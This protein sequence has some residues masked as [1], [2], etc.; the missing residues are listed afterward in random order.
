MFGGMEEMQEQMQQKLLSIEVAAQAGDGLVKIKANAAR[1]ILD[2]SIDS[3]LTDTEEI[4]DLVLETMN[5]VLQLAAIK[6]QEESSK[7]LSQMMP[8]GMGDLGALFGK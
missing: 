4:E 1:Q 6:E 8:P 2:V 5:R 7:M 3:S